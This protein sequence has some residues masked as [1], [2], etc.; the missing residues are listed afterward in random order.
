MA[1][2]QNEPAIDAIAALIPA[3]LR[4]LYA[5]EFAGRHLSPDNLPRLIEAIAGRE[6]DVEGVLAF[7]RVAGW[8]ERLAPVRACLEGA[9]AAA[10]E[11]VTGLLAAGD[12]PQPIVAA[13][14]AMRGYA[15]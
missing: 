7:S 14:R 5:L 10:G 9:A 3:T 11:G 2:A 13:Y 8:P 4:A 6:V 1:D 12:A 15:R